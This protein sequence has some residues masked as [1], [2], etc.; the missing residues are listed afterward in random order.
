MFRSVY[1]KSLFLRIIGMTLA[2]TQTL[3]LARLSGAH[4]LGVYSS[5]LA[6]ITLL[7]MPVAAGVLDTRN[8]GTTCTIRI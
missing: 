7:A 3:L 1:S 2:V 6:I 4:S 5:L 8:R